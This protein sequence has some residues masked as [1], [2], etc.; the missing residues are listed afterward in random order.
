M[1]RKG[2]YLFWN[3]KSLIIYDICVVFK[4]IGDVKKFLVWNKS[5]L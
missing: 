1:K 2:V 4:L 3:V 5:R